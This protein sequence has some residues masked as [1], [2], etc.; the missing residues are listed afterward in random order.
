MAKINGAILWKGRSKID[1]KPIMLIATGLAKGSSNTK[2]GN[3]VQTWILRDD[4]TP[5]DAINSGADKSICGDCKHRGDIVDGRN[6]GRACYVT[7]WQAPRNIYGT[8][9]RGVY[10]ELTPKEAQ[11]ILAGRNVRL[12]AYGDPAAIPFGI[13]ERILKFAERGTGYT[14]QWKDCNPKFARYCMASADTVSEAEQARALGYRTFRVGAHDENLQAKLEFLC[15]ASK[16]AGAK[17]N[18]AAC[19]ACGGTDSPNRASVFIPV[20]GAAGKIKV[21]NQKRESAWN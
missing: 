3:L 4:M 10:P 9:Q 6:V 12:G 11:T 20:H 16:E 13:W 8:A 21:F 19:L 7:V 17:T 5:M 1:R 18:C 14:H 2:T 15:P